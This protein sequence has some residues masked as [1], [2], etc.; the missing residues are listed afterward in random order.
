MGEAIEE[1]RGHLGIAKNAGPL[2]EVRFL[3]MTTLV[4]SLS[5]LRS[6]NSGAP[7][8]ALNGRYPSSS[9]ITNSVFNSTS[10]VFLAFP[11]A[12][13]C[14]SAFTSPTSALVLCVLT[15]PA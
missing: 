1:C 13:S 12:F 5:L 6:G 9:R 15:S 4:R 3:V 11:C 10:A 8:E 7:P 14:S 2:A